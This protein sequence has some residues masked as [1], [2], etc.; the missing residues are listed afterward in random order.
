MTRT[1]QPLGDRGPEDGAVG[2][3]G[4]L[5]EEDE[6][7][8]LA[9][10]RLREREAR[11]DE[12]GAGGA[13][14][15]DEHGAVGAHRER[16]AQRV[17]RAL[18]T[19]RDDD[20]L[21]LAGRVLQ[22][23]R[24]LDRVRVEGVQRALAGAVEALR[25]GIDPLVRGRVRNLLHA[26]GDL[27]RADSNDAPRAAPREAS[28]LLPLSGGHCS[29]GP[30]RLP[31]FEREPVLDDPRPD[32]S[33]RACSSPC[34]R[35]CSAQGRR[36]HRRLRQGADARLPGRS[37]RRPTPTTSA[38]PRGQGAHE[39]N[40]MHRAAARARPRR[41]GGHRQ[42]PHDL[43]ARPA[44]CSTSRARAAPSTSTST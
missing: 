19:H 2:V 38:T 11:G 16:L 44:A 32:D 35:S 40:D 37:A 30:G 10:E 29:E 12:I 14:V 24:L 42:V 21:A 3:G 22:P 7:G 41:R 28:E 18:R 9:L 39:G 25:P 34:S 6:V 1:A 26:D 13:V 31:P 43:V 4:L 15:G 8:L 20:D 5:A 36:P 27:H 23:Q 33:P 17:E